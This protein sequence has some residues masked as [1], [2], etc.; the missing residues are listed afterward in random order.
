MFNYII[1]RISVQILLKIVKYMFSPFQPSDDMMLMFYSYYKQ[2]T[3]GP[4][5]IHRPMGFWDTRGKTKWDAWSS[6]GTMTKEEAMRN[7]IEHIQLVSP[8]QRKPMPFFC[9]IKKRIICQSL[10]F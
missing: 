1:Y 2:A 9:I 6:L 5:N 7:Y 10:Y 3:V 4:C 8:F